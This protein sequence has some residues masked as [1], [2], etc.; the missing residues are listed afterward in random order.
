MVSSVRARRGDGQVRARHPGPA[1]HGPDLGKAAG[2]ARRDL[3]EEK[4]GAYNSADVLALS[5]HASS[6]ST[7]A[8]TTS[9]P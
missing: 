9:A 1:A 4:A 3:A 8:L 5:A 6:P 7:A 2:Q